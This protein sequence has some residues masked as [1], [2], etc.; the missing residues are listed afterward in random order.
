MRISSATTE[1]S[2]VEHFAL[3]LSPI[4]IKT[5]SGIIPLLLIELS[6]YGSCCVLHAFQY[7]IYSSLQKKENIK[8]F[9]RCSKCDYHWEIF[10]NM[11]AY[12]MPSC[13]I[14]IEYCNVQGGAVK[15]NFVWFKALFLRFLM[16]PCW[17]ILYGQSSCYAAFVQTF[18]LKKCRRLFWEISVFVI[19]QSVG[20]EDRYQTHVCTV[21]MT[22]LAG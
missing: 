15:V 13:R 14:N 10:R 22:L 17:I 20:W 19:L 4:S 5:L 6:C 7:F 1:P 2:P 8:Q 11:H 12:I 18:H 9:P 21:T 3:T 16:L